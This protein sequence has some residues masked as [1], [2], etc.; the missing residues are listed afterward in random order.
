M[1]AHF[2]FSFSAY[3]LFALF[4]N[5]IHSMKARKTSE[6]EK[7]GICLPGYID[8]LTIVGV[9]KNRR[10]WVD[11]SML[12]TRGKEDDLMISHQGKKL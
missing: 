9:K 3:S 5:S 12:W 2:N 6:A 4:S 11:Y 7:F 8:F 1:N 10:S